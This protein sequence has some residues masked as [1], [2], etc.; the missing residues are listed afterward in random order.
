M[1]QDQRQRC[2]ALLGF[3]AMCRTSDRRNFRP[4]DVR[5]ERRLKLSPNNFM[6][7]VAL[8]MPELTLEQKEYLKL[9]ADIEW[10]EA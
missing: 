4:D 5:S 2:D 1:N 3:V 7:A 8:R 10:I 6:D 9:N